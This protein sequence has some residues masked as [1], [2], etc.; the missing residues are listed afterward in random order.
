[1]TSDVLITW[2][3]VTEAH[4]PDAIELDTEI[5]IWVPVING[6]TA[7]RLAFFALSR[8][9]EA[10][11]EEHRAQDPASVRRWAGGR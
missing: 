10:I 6:Q 4:G 1:M 2:S 8:R 7:L 3:A 9:V 11:C 5:A